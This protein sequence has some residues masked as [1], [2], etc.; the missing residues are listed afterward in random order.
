MLWRRDSGGG[1]RGGGAREGAGDSCHVIHD[2]NFCNFFN[3]LSFSILNK[4]IYI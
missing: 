1:K 3:L 4:G 2:M